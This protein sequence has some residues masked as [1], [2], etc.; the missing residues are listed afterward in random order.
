MEPMSPMK[1]MDF[2]PAW[3]PEQLGKPS[4][5]GGQNTHKFAFFPDKRRLAVQQAGMVTVYDAGDHDI[6]GMSDSNGSL[7]FVSQKGAVTLDEL[8]K[9]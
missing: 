4:A 9:A 7:S 6:S 1:P 3:W 2:G 8:R 5:S